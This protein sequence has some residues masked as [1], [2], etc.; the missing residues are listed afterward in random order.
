MRYIT[1]I[2]KLQSFVRNGVKTRWVRVQNLT[3]KKLS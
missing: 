2:N 1:C 3:R